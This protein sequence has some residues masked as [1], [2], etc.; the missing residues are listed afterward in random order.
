M[1]TLNLFVS[2]SRS[3]RS[4]KEI[5]ENSPIIVTTSGAVGDSIT[6]E[7]APLTSVVP[8]LTSTPATRTYSFDK[9]FGP[10]ADQA[11][12]YDTVVKDTLDEVMMG[13]NCTIFA[14]GQTGTGK[15]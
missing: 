14:Y 12:V 11:M 2:L 8:S 13:Y 6:I 5:A 3:G 15:T 4:P 7:T 10:E 9:V 1:L